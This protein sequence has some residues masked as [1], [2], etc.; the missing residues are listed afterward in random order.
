MKKLI[1]GL[2]ATV[3]MVNLSFA[4]Q[5]ANDFIGHNET[6]FV[7]CVTVEVS[8]GFF[9]VSTELC[10]W[11]HSAHSPTYRCCLGN[12]CADRSMNS[13]NL[14]YIDIEK[15]DKKII[16]EIENNKLTKLKISKSS[17][18]KEGVKIVDGEY[19]ILKDENGRYLIVNILTK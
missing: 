3:F 10:C 6:I 12:G 17:T 7:T 11:R 14:G 5:N 15:L 13:S 4:N 8:V 1:F 19:D 9:S 2:I 16:S 18:S